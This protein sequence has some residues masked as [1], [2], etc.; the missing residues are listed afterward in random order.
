MSKILSLLVLVLSGCGVSIYVEDEPCEVVVVAPPA[1][2]TAAA[3]VPCVADDDPVAC[4]CCFAGLAIACPAGV[5]PPSADGPLTLPVC[6]P[7]Q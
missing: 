7:R 4:G 5:V 1:S 2:P 6:S 3:T